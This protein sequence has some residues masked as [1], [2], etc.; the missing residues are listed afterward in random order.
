MLKLF[1]P[2]PFDL[3]IFIF[4]IRNIMDFMAGLNHGLEVFF[5]FDFASVYNHGPS[6]GG[7]GIFAFFDFGRGCCLMFTGRGQYVQ[8]GLGP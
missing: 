6:F 2:D 1:R 4:K 7:Q 8:Y 3:M 5:G